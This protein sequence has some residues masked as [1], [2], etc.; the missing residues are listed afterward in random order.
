VDV[1]PYGPYGWANL[2]NTQCGGFRQSPINIVPN[3]IVR[4]SQLVFV[5]NLIFFQVASVPGLSALSLAY[6]M[7]AFWIFNTGYDIRIA[8]RAGQGKQVAIGTRFDI[9]IVANVGRH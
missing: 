9:L 6:P 3:D 7:N 1:K 5:F 4:D 8:A 2:P